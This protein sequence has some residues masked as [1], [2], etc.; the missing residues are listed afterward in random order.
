MATM[1]HKH[2]CLAIGCPTLIAQGEKYCQAHKHLKPR[3]TRPSANYR[4]YG[5]KWQ[6][7]RLDWLSK[8]PKCVKCGD[9][10]TVVDHIIPHKGD[11]KLF[12]ANTNWQSM[13]GR[14]HRLKGLNEGALVKKSR[15]PKTY[16]GPRPRYRL[17]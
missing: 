4:G 8:H 14:C 15:R 9:N 17:S 16:V 6:K 2:P 11:D 3:D 10:A 13:C 5:A 12:W 7:A 1:L